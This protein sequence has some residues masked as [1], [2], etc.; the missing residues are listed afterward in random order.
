ML[1]LIVQLWA[2]FT[3]AMAVLLVVVIAGQAA[4]QVVLG[5]FAGGGRSPRRMAGPLL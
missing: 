2:L 3:V 4:A 1:V 5:A